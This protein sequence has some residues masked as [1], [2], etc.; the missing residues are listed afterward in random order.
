MKK[1]ML[2]LIIALVLI[3]VGILYV[4]LDKS[5]GIYNNGGGSGTSEAEI[6]QLKPGS[7]ESTESATETGTGSGAGGGSGTDGGDTGTD[8][9]ENKT[10]PEDINTQPCGFY[11]GEYQICAGT[12]LSGTCQQEGG[13]C[14]CKI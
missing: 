3:S 2:F 8:T 13:S 1:I 7:S 12:C 6:P 10:L 5:N 14:Y 9:P 11:F 4:V